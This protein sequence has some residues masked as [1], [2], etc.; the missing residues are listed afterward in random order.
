MIPLH[1]DPWFI[2]RFAEDRIVGRF[3]LEDVEPGRQVSVFKID[4][5]TGHRLGLLR[6]SVVGE[7][8]WVNLVEPIIV[9]A[10]EA[11]IAV[12]QEESPDGPVA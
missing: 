10:G 9:K 2:F 6:T 12:L 11:F 4:L 7:G 5:T 8:G 1:E 3:H